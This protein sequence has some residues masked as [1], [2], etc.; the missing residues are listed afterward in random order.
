[1]KRFIAPLVDP[2]VLTI[3][4]SLHASRFLLFLFL[5]VFVFLLDEPLGPAPLSFAPPLR[6]VGHNGSS[7]T[8]SGLPC[9]HHLLGIAVPAVLVLF[10][11]ILHCSALPATS[12]RASRAHLIL[13]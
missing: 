2:V 4:R 7:R 8:G 5:F 9:L 12:S 13:D 10:F 1:M 6:H 11:D 3:A